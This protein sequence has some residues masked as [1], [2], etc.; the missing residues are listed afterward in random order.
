M[1]SGTRVPAAT[2]LSSPITAPFRMVAPMP[3]RQ[4]EPMVHPCRVTECPTV[5]WSA[6]TV[7]WVACMTWMTQLSW[8]L[9][10]GPMTMEFTSPRTTAFIQMLAWAPS[11]TSPITW[12]ETST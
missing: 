2:M 6:S 5:T 3:M 7:G 8:M 12:A 11:S 10:P 1:P 9:V 4:Q